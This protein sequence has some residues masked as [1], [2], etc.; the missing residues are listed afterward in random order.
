M[1]RITIIEI[2]TLL[3]VFLALAIYFSPRFMTNKEDLILSKIKTSNAIFT[4][5]IIETFA[6]D[7]NI[8]PSIVAKNVAQEL[9]KLEKNPYNNKED[10][11]TFDKNCTSCNYVEYD[12]NALMIIV[13]TYDDKKNLIAR[14]VIKPPSYVPYYKESKK[15]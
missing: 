12:D 8:K 3:I 1:K 14:T 9:N 13:T 4:S 2:T 10:A 15:K 6:Q 7:K 11:Y 5:K